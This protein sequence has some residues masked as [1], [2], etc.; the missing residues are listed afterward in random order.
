MYSK[1]LTGETEILD[2]L[3]WDA[4]DTQWRWKKVSDL[5]GAINCRGVS[6][7][8]I[9][10]VLA[11]LEKT[12]PRVKMRRPTNRLQYFLPPVCR[13]T[14]YHVQEDF[15]EVFPDAPVTG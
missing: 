11:K 3:N 15:D 7:V 1:P 10:R 4:P 8:Q 5:M 6:A 14:P 2:Q 9:G 13:S 12:D